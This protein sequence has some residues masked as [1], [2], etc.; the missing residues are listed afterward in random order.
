[1]SEPGKYFPPSVFFY[2][3]VK[4]PQKKP[5]Y[6]GFFSHHMG[7]VIDMVGAVAVVAGALGAVTKLHIGVI[8]W[9]RFMSE[10]GKYFIVEARAMPEIFRKVAEAK[11]LLDLQ[12]V[13]QGG[14]LR[15]HGHHSAAVHRDILVNGKD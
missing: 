12:G 6:G 11:R 3:P 7:V 13:P 5:P 8:D 9:R 15:R 1:M 14:G 10:P 2:I 4:S